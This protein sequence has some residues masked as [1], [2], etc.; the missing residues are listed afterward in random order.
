M[1]IYAAKPHDLQSGMLD[2]PEEI[3]HGLPIRGMHHVTA[4][5][6]VN[7]MLVTE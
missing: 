5:C 1:S 6:D 4:E 3:L 2:L 7:G